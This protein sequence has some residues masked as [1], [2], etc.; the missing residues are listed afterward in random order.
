MSAPAARLIIT[1]VLLAAAGPAGAGTWRCQTADGRVEYR[2]HPCATTAAKTSADPASGV[3][4]LA[5]P[6]QR[7]PASRADRAAPGRIPVNRYP[8]S[9]AFDDVRIDELMAI[10]AQFDGRRL[11]LDPAAAGIRIACH[12]NSMPWD[13][14]VADIAARAGLDIRV[15]AHDIVVKKR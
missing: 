1:L 12:Y 2:D 8:I 6:P 15:D 14:A 9:L 11:V 3:A 10:L 13:A 4:A 7:A 5:A